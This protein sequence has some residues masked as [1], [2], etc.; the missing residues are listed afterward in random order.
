MTAFSPQ[1]IERIAEAIHERYRRRQAGRNPPADPSLEPW[2]TLSERL[3]G[4]NRSQAMDVA[5][6]LAAIHC[7]AV[8]GDGQSGFAFTAAELELLAEREHTRWVAERRHSGWTDGAV[9][10]PARLV[11]PYLVSYRD[12]P[13]EIRELDREAVRSIPALLRDVGLEIRRI[14]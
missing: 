13:E 2:A 10:D 8:P 4:S 6:K 11:T 5:A 9:R 14:P 1:V 3:K 12:L 7:A